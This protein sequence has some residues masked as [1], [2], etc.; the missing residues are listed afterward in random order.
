MLL[1]TIGELFPYITNNINLETTRLIVLII[2]FIFI[3]FL[4]L[5]FN[6]IIEIN[7]CGMQN[8]TKKNISKR[9]SFEDLFSIDDDNDEYYNLYRIKDREK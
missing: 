4:I 1:I 2:G 3:I 5:I 6:E 7:C 9:A 8:N